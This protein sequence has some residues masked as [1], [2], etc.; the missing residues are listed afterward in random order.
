MAEAPKYGE[1]IARLA[2]HVRYLGLNLERPD[3]QRVWL[4]HEHYF[5]EIMAAARALDAQGPQLLTPP[6]DERRS[7]G[8]EPQENG[9][10]AP[11]ASDAD[12][13]VSEADML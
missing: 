10:S 12:S 2:D 6:A 8:Q 11:S 5:S 9:K 1:L 4:P 7:D 13:D 3:G